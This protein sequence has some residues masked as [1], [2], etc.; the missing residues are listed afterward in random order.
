MYNVSHGFNFTFSKCL[1]SH[2]S[3][4]LKVHLYF[5]GFKCH[6]YHIL[7]FHMYLS[8]FLDFLFYSTGPVP[9][10]HC[11]NYRNFIVF[12]NVW[13]SQSSHNFSFQCF[14]LAI[15][16]YLFLYANFSI[17][18]SSSIKRCIDIFIE[19]VSHVL[20]QRELISLQC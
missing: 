14:F 8:L 16:M 2:P 20:T 3:F 13:Q 18:L 10:P 9:V 6:P 5:G 1:L 19:I 17:N 4:I 7:N 15:M 11:F 12:F